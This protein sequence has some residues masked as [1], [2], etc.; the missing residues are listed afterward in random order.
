MG[1]PGLRERAEMAH[2]VGIGERER[3]V[4]P[5]QRVWH[6]RIVRGEVADVQLVDDDVFRRGERRLDERAPAG[7]RERRIV[8]IDD[9]AAERVA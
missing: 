4:R 5:A 3:L 9:L 6:A 8:E 7:R 2:P 1:Q